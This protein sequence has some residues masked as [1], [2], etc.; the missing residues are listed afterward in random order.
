MKYIKEYNSYNTGVEELGSNL[1]RSLYQVQKKYG[2]SF[3]TKRELDFFHNFFTKSDIHDF[4]QVSGTS[5]PRRSNFNFRY[6]SSID[7]INPIK[8]RIH[9]LGDDYYYI[10]IEFL[11]NDQSKYSEYNRSNKPDSM[12]YLIDNFDDLVDFLKDIYNIHK[13]LD[14]N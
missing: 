4:F 2:H 6:M 11:I 14:N 8:V 10:S 7:P 5:K 12:S 1:W 3:F 13:I 9:R